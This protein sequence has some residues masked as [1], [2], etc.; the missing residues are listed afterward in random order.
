MAQPP[1]ALYFGDNLTILRDWFPDASVDLIYLDPPFNSNRSYNLLFKE[2]SGEGSAAQLEAFGDTWTWDRAARDTF[3]ALRQG[4][5]PPRVADML[6]A[7]AR[8]VGHNDMMAYLVMMTARLLELHRVL[9]PT[10]S[11]YLHCDPTAAHYLK[12]VLDNI[13]GIEHYRDQIIWKRTSA[14]SDSKGYGNNY[15][16]ILFYTKSNDYTWNPIYTPYTEEYAT[17]YY[18]YKD[19]DGRH[20]K[21]GDLT[22]PGGRG[23]VYEYKGVTRAWRYTKENMLALEAQGKIFITRNGFPRLKQYLDEMPGMPLQ[24]LWDDIL[25]IVSWSKEGLG[26]P[27]QK[28]VAL[29]E[30]IIQASSNPGDIVLD[31][32]CGCGTAVVAAHKLGRRWRGIDI[33]HLAIA[34]MRARLRDT[35]GPDIEAAYKVWGEPEDLAGARA[36]ALDSANNGRYQFQWWALSLV[37]A[38]PEGEAK[39]GADRG[40]DGRIA[41]L[42]ADGS[43]HQVVVSVKSGHVSVDQVRDLGHVIDREGA[44]IGVLLTLEPPSGPMRKEALGKGT[45]T[46]AWTGQAYDRL[47]ILTIEELLHGAR[48]AMPPTGQAPGA[49]APRAR[50]ADAQQ[51]RLDL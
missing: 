42:E 14:H 17:A 3:D 43:R 32:F 36:L 11:L 33:T 27:T 22:A 34:L 6:D 40:I 13:F 30:R 7:L 9:K 10:G 15:D 29:L 26:Y 41:Y 20:F 8:F 5:A 16:I 2:K 50:R 1:N 19:D 21:S 25:P 24:A 12:V 23:P 47:Q 35:F 44:A 38:Q 4:G 39:K 48:I 49:T 51:A 37:G 31:P 46:S 18:R 28:P 45:V